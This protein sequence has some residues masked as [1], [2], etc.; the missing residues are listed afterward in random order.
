MSLSSTLA[1]TLAADQSPTRTT[2]G[3][4]KRAT[5]TSVPSTTHGTTW[6]QGIVTSLWNFFAEPSESESEADALGAW[7]GVRKGRKRCQSVGEMR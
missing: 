4:I 3:S 2:P 1:S 5:G 7:V 6:T